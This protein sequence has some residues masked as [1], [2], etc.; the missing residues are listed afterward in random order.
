MTVDAITLAKQFIDALLVHD[1]ERAFGLFD[2]RAVVSVTGRHVLA[3]SFGS[4]AHYRETRQWVFR[5]HD[6]GVDLVRC[7]AFLTGDN[8]AIA[9]VEERAHRGSTHLV[10]RSLY[11]VTAGDAG[12][13]EIR[14]VPENPYALDAFWE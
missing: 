14:I 6:A 3:G 5:E 11:L 12:A 13:L 8:V 10:Y 4:V 2:D 1:E 7:D 9:L